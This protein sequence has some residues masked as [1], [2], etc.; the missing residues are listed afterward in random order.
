MDAYHNAIMYNADVHFKGKTVL[1]VGS[2]T[3]ILAI[4]AAMAGARR[5][6]AV[7]AS[8]IGTHIESLVEAHGVGD[9]VTVVRNRM[10]KVTSSLM[11]AEGRV[12]SVEMGGLTT[13]LTCPC[14]CGRNIT[15]SLVIASGRASG[16]GGCNCV[17]V[18]G[19]LPAPRVDGR[20][21]SSC[22][23]P[24]AG[25][26]RRDVPVACAP[27]HSANRPSPLPRAPAR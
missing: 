16:E 1:D 20:V 10:E 5:V 3:G 23:R 2:G 4:W 15:E 12:H 19:L 26:W 6:Y 11:Q 25:T 9:V 7:E 18:D 27:S 17:G 14:A 13:I 21:C 22:S 24:L 8:S